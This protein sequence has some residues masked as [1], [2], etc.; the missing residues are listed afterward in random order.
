MNKVVLIMA[1]LMWISTAIQ[2]QESIIRDIDYRYL[3]TLIALAKKNYPRLKVMQEE[4]AISKSAYNT[5]KLTYLDM[6]NGS[7]IYRP[8]N[9]PAVSELNPYFINGYQVSVGV[10]LAGLIRKPSS[11]RQAKRS[12][13]I[14]QLETERFEA[15]LESDVR[16]AYYSYLQ[17]INM[18]KLRTQYAQDSKI[19]FDRV[20]NQ[21][22]RGE[23][24]VDAYTIARSELSEANS[25]VIQAEIN[26]LNAK[27]G[28][29]LL[30]GV[31]LDSIN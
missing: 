3:D 12:Y 13:R 27:D 5:S 22:E 25:S 17:S 11:V 23:A 1:I 26:Y 18:L 24:P 21:F 7:Y 19:T 10:N 14:A 16:S 29:E 20:Q 15:E 9:R 4:E 2:A 31:K 30:I 8:R 28:L 6:F